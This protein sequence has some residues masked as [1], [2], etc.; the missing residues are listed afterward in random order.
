MSVVESRPAMS[1]PPRRRPAKP[2]RPQR[3]LY[4]RYHTTLIKLASL[5]VVIALWQI[6]GVK[7][8]YTTSNPRA[9][10]HAGNKT[11]TSDVLPAFK[12]TLQSF[13]LGFAICVV[14][15]IP[16]GLAIARS[17]F[18]ELILQP[19]TVM[20]FSVPFIAL[21]PVLIVAFGVSFPLRVSVVI[22]TGLFPIVVNTYSGARLVDPNLLDVGKTFVT[23]RTR[24]LLSI[25][26]PG[27]LRYIFAG[28]RIGF[29]R[30]MIGAIVVELEA[31][32]VGVG[33]L[34]EKDAQDLAIADFFVCLILLGF[35]ALLCTTIIRRAESWSVEPWARRSVTRGYSRAYETA[36]RLVSQTVNDSFSWVAQGPI[37]AALRRTVA[38]I[39]RGFDVVTSRTGRIFHNFLVGWVVRLLTLALVIE[40]WEL[41]SHT[42][43]KAVLPSPFSVMHEFYEQIFVTHALLG[44]MS[45]SIEVLFVGYALSVAIG[46]PIG[47]AMG[48]SKL[49]ENVLDPYIS[50]IYALP[51]VAFV[52]LMIVWLGFG[53]KFR[54]AYVIVSAV[55]PVIINT[56]S[57]VKNID[58]ELISTGRSF[59][60]SERT[61]LRTIVIPGA[62][63]FMLT[64][65]R[66]ALSASWVGVVVS[67][68]LSTQSGLGGLITEYS[69]HF[70]TADMF[71]PIIS[72]MIIAVIILQVSTRLEK[73]FT[74]GRQ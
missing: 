41:K 8:P 62:V 29:A 11:L 61:I 12:Y 14:V 38:V 30:G 13:G 46:I 24:T 49:L 28:I 18:I 40:L 72:I 16:L 69:D 59:C 45:S 32:A 51:H 73:R 3:S 26:F 54:V 47:I 70:L 22:L 71:V 9:V 57:G 43:S 2:V 35:F 7:F 31:S 23:S 33:S 74:R 36:F 19:Y 48:R 50:F 5:A 25:V 42:V 55:F 21:F 66:I 27:S 53:L 6:I 34:L 68:I 10:W 17:K 52:P 44:P 63:P 37:G 4:T 67:E 56:L 39:A 60:A 58:P 65:A 1:A 64:G 20:L 15:G